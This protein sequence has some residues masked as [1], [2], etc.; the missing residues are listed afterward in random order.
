VS[1]AVTRLRQ[2][3]AGQHPIY[4]YVTDEAGRLI[5]VVPSRRLLLSDP[6]TLVGEL[7]VHPVHSVAESAM[8]GS[9]L[10]LL[11]EQRLLALPVVDEA[12]RLTGVLNIAGMTRAVVDS[13]QQ[14][15]SDET[16]QLTGLRAPVAQ[17]VPWLLVS[18]AAGLSCA[19]LLNLFAA[20]LKDA[21]AIAFF[22]PLVISIG[23]R[24]A[25][26]AALPSLLRGLRTNW[27]KPASA[28]PAAWRAEVVLCTASVL[29]IVAGVALGWIRLTRV[30]GTVVCSIL[31]ASGAGLSVG[32]TIP[33][34]MRRWHLET[35]VASAP[36][37]LALTDI[38]ALSCYLA[39]CGVFV[40]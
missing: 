26:H 17:R 19:F 13:E 28:T 22:V 32:Y 5:G 15:A 3:C 33:R 2:E 39:L 31:A 25:F 21:I 16:F 11:A 7:M 30:A 20:T 10:A 12:G 1:Q 38:A 40:R 23:E 14:Q 29:L 34:L 4:F 24:V 37:V 9:A 6:S 8:F 35:R 27:R 18:L 36:V